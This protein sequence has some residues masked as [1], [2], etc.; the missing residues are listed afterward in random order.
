MRPVHRRRSRTV[1]TYY[2][3]ASVIVAQNVSRYEEAKELL[4]RGI[5]INPNLPEP[6]Y[7]KGKF[8]LAMNRSLE[9][10]EAF[11]RSIHLNPS[12]RDPYHQLG[13]AYVQAGDASRAEDS[14]RMVFSLDPTNAEAALELGVLLSEGLDMDKVMEARK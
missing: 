7:A 13:L 5:S 4:D 10:T 2:A 9:A 14:F 11:K 12:L 8:L 6:H 3:L 1:E